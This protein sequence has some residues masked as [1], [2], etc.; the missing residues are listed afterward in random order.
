[1]R[2]HCDHAI[3]AFVIR[4]GHAVLLVAAHE[5]YV[6]ARF[7]RR[8]ELVEESANPGDIGGIGGSL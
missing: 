1:M 2:L 7:H 3:P 5:I 4:L 8:A 6:D